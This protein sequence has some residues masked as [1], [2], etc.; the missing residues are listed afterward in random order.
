[1]EADDSEGGRN[2]LC[3]SALA[4]ASPVYWRTGMQITLA[5]TR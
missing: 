5:W 1:M 3:H 2:E 4:L